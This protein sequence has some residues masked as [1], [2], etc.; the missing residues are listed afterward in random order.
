MLVC[1]AEPYQRMTGWMC[2]ICDVRAAWNGRDCDGIMRLGGLEINEHAQQES[3]VVSNTEH[4]Y[5]PLGGLQDTYTEILV[6]H[7]EAVAKYTRAFHAFQPRTE[8]L[9]RHQIPDPLHV[10]LASHGAP[11]LYSRST[12][13]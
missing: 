10:T 8:S 5:T 4:I 2:V 11:P 13:Q 1:I 3:I 7:I 6:N 9:W 12:V